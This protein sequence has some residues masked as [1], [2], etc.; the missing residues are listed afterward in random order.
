MSK[1]Y[2]NLLGVSRNASADEIKKAYRGLA[3][4]YHPDRNSGDRAAEEKF[5]EI[6]EAYAVLSDAEKRRQYDMFGSTEF[7]QRFSRE[8][9]F[10]GFDFSSVFKEFDFGDF[11][12]QAFSAGKGGDFHQFR[13]DFGGPQFG[14]DYQFNRDI[15]QKGK[16]I[17][18]ELPVSLVEVY[19]GG[20]KIVS[21]KRGGRTERVSVKIPPGIEDGKKLRISGKGEPGLHGGAPGNL[22]LKVKI[23]Q[24]SLF[25]REGANIV[26]DR[27][28]PFSSAV[29]GQQINVPALDGRNLS[30]LVPAGTQNNTS[31]RLK[32]F[33]LP[34]P[35]S[36]GR[37]DQYVRIIVKVPGKVTGKQKKVIEELAAA[38]L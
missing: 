18:L 7:H 5:K 28:I 36:S 23:E 14:R 31:L 11:F 15:K 33:G 4:K 38:G 16:D 29:L 35:D 19:H 2:Y 1:D 20:E 34:F 22:Y 10:R 24:H 32:G 30:V 9:I 8:D 12:S 3:L 25:K 17:V 26:L 37:G 13:Y 27:E 6:N 21:F